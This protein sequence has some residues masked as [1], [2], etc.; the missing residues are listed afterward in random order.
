METDTHYNKSAN[1]RPL[2]NKDENTLPVFWMHNLDYKGPDIRKEDCKECWLVQ[3]ANHR[4]SQHNPASSEAT[5]GHQSFQG[6]SS[7]RASKPA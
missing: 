3:P 2:K 6:G 4:F 1:P 5:P 7:S